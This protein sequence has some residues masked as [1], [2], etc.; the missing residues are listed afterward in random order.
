MNAVYPFQKSQRCSA[1]SK[2]IRRPCM[3]PAVTGR[4]GSASFEDPQVR[5]ESLPQKRGV[6]GVL[7]GESEA[8]SDGW[9]GG[10]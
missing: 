2:R 5:Q 6:L 9:E 4:Q 1:T 8:V 10:L 3:A 7:R